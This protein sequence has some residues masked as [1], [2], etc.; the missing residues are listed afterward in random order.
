[1]QHKNNKI[2]DPLSV[3]KPHFPL[4][5]SQKF[6]CLGATINYTQLIHDLAKDIFL[7]VLI[8]NTNAI[9]QLQDETRD[10]DTNIKDISISEVT[11]VQEQPAQRG[12][13]RGSKK[14]RHRILLDRESLEES[15]NS[16]ELHVS[17][18]METATLKDEPSDPN[19]EE[20]HLKPVVDVQQYLED[21]DKNNVPRYQYFGHLPNRTAS[22]TKE[23]HKTNEPQTFSQHPDDFE[24]FNKTNVDAPSDTTHDF[25]ASQESPFPVNIQQYL[26]HMV[27]DNAGELPE[28]NDVDTFEPYETYEAN[29]QIQKLMEKVSDDEEE[30]VKPL[31]PRQTIQV[32]LVDETKKKKKKKSKKQKDP[33]I[34]TTSDDMVGELVENNVELRKP[35]PEKKVDTK[36]IAV[37]TMPVPDDIDSEDDSD[38]EIL[39]Y[40]RSAIGGYLINTI[41][42]EQEDESPLSTP[43][44]NNFTSPIDQDE[45]HREKGFVFRDTRDHEPTPRHPYQKTEKPT[46][47]ISPVLPP[48]YFSEPNIGQDEVR[49]VEFSPYVHDQSPQ[50]RQTYETPNQNDYEKDQS[51]TISRQ[52]FTV[53]S[54][55][56]GS[57][58]EKATEMP[59]PW[60]SEFSQVENGEPYNIHSYQLQDENTGFEFDRPRE[61]ME[62]SPTDEFSETIYKPRFEIHDFVEEDKRQRNGTVIQAPPNKKH[63]MSSPHSPIDNAFLE[64]ELFKRGETVPVTDEPELVK[65]SYQPKYEV[66]H[67][68]KQDV[69]EKHELTKNTS[70][71]DFVLEEDAKVETPIRPRFEPRF[72]IIDS[73]PKEENKIDEKPSYPEPV[74]KIER[75]RAPIIQEEP[76]PLLNQ[77]SYEIK[78]FVLEEPSYA[79]KAE[80][81]EQ[82]DI[83]DSKFHDIS[84][85]IQPVYRPRYILDETPDYKTRTVQPNLEEKED[86][87][88]EPT[89]KEIIQPTYQLRY[90]VTELEEQYIEKDLPDGSLENTPSPQI[91]EES[92]SIRSVYQPKYEIRDFM[93]Q[94]TQDKEGQP[95]S[96]IPDIGQS[97]Y[98]PRYKISDV[99]LDDQSQSNETP[100]KSLQVKNRITAS[101]PFVEGEP[102]PEPA[103]ETPKPEHI[104]TVYQPRYEIRSFVLEEQPHKPEET[105]II[106][107]ASPVVEEPKP[108]RSFRAPKYEINDI[109]LKDEELE[110]NRLEENGNFT[111]PKYEIRDFFVEEQPEYK[112]THPPTFEKV[113]VA[114]VPFVE[115]EPESTHT[116]SQPKTIREFVLKDE[117]KVK[118]QPREARESVTVTNVNEVL[119]EP[120][121]DRS[122]YKPQYEI[123]NF[124]LEDDPSSTVTPTPNKTSTETIVEDEPDFYR[125][126]EPRHEVKAFILEE[127]PLVERDHAKPQEKTKIDET[128]VALKEPQFTRSVNSPKYEI[129]DLETKT[130]VREFVMQ[131]QPE[132][133]GISKPL[134]TDE[135]EQTSAETTVEDAPDFYRP[136]EPRHEVKAFVL[137]EEPLVERDQAKP[138][139]KTKTDE[140]P[141]AL[142][143][144]QFT[145]SV[146]SPKY[147]IPKLETKSKVREFVIE[148]QPENKG[149][150]KP[151]ATD[152]TV[153]TS[154]ETTVEDAP[155]FYRPFEPRHEVKAFVLDE[156]PLVE[157]DQAKPQEKTKIDETL[158]ALKEPEFTR[159]VTSPKY[160]IPDL[161]TKSKV[162]EFV[163]QEQPENKGISKP[164]VTDETVQTSAETMVEDEPDFY[165]P[166]KPRHEVK[167]FVLDEEPLVERDQAKPQEKTRTDEIPVALKEPEFTR[168][169]NSP[170]YEIPDLET[171]T[172]VREFVIQEQPE[173]KGISKP[174]VTDETVQTSAENIVQDEPEF[175]RPFEPRHEVKAFVLDEEPL[176]ERNLAK[177]QEKTMTDET[178][179]AL[180]E[181]EFTRSVNSPKYEIP[182]LETKTKVREFVIEEQPENKDIPKYPVTDETVQ[183]SAET[184]VEDAPDFYRP[185]EPRHELKTFVLDEEPLV[186]QNEAEP[187]EKTKIDETPFALNEP[188]FTRSV[189]S[190]KYEI[191]DLETKTKV[192][193]FVIEEQPENKDIP[194]YPVTDETVQ[195]S[196]ETTVEDAPDFYRPFEP[197]HQL[198]TFVLDEE[199]LVER[200]QVKPQEKTRTDEIPVAL[201]EP[202]LPD[203]L[204]VQNMKFQT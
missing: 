28:V 150:S 82:L 122:H 107:A 169:I 73:I 152:E 41:P 97:P 2:S 188:E 19:E 5:Q 88:F 35:A 133:K 15:A 81:D 136:F 192:R 85:P 181:P 83:D 198:K 180:K 148:E 29:N 90:E 203:L 151:P 24:D 89:G 144:P 104:S 32:I 55:L 127:E 9:F 64:G 99:V 56:S 161:E 118:E 131:E 96:D 147:E 74:Q 149:I 178:P 10:D 8:V 132:N 137:D 13:V 134:V 167:A 23:L 176:V 93:L 175:Y 52:G 177:P 25:P 34:D 66:H 63:K 160:E 106:P 135:T 45:I 70:K 72:E 105:E 36:E 163:I 191:P 123:R 143:E 117:P 109:R 12:P 1:M 166:F 31:V 184:T 21:D 75:S 44:Q 18:A 27:E 91:E 68:I 112:R 199:P 33:K 50:T 194:K 187:Q 139:E 69:K 201:N 46:Y 79:D 77:S 195:T 116:I 146:T 129:P 186:E 7:P 145:R 103:E 119:E 71:N 37:Q 102:E 62:N 100:L 159:S 53:D 173:N 78:N 179:V 174:L 51:T 40:Q 162:R 172:K 43:D 196:A 42:E 95:I 120:E 170:K 157:R 171:Q 128:P 110:P 17:P 86:L 60:Q 182:D 38:Q 54:V 65:S 153:Q 84:E 121:I 4:N 138:Q 126:F 125:S 130:E 140:T 113:N 6:I 164:F 111:Q 185:F 20:K 47:S 76:E 49:P 11:Q 80:D 202:N 14:R 67:F 30:L 101:V 48:K 57:S 92:G 189:N 22:H 156:E 154:A 26:G 87:P 3:K 158:V 58:D 114:Q 59:K 94:E 200:D 141:V 16:D 204:I 108:T 142:N 165:R 168:S 98:Q 193:E 39:Q 115:E 190:P 155:H 124:I 197:R 61:D 183:T